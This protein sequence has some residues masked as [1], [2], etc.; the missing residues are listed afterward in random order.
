V[1]PPLLLT[2][3]QDTYVFTD[4][5]L[6]HGD[7]MSTTEF[8]EFYELLFEDSKPNAAVTFHS[9]VREQFEGPLISIFIEAGWQADGSAYYE[10]SQSDQQAQIAS[11]EAFFENEDDTTAPF[12]DCSLFIDTVNGQCK[13][14]QRRLEHCMSRPDK[15]IGTN[16][17]QW[18]PYVTKVFPRI[19]CEIRNSELG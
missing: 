18:C 19:G 11:V 4:R 14:A 1:P 15:Q 17:V 7:T 3:L 8:F 10:I 13:I 12:S 5:P 16:V 2:P 6:R 9:D